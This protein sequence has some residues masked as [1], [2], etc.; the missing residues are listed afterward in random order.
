MARVFIN[1]GSAVPRYALQEDPKAAFTITRQTFRDIENF[2]ADNKASQMR[3]RF[4]M[5]ALINLCVLTVKA[6]AQKQSMGPVAPN[7]RSNPAFAYRVPV[8]RITGRY[9]AGWRVRK[10]GNA[11]WMLYNESKEA[12]LIEYGLYMR[13]RRP[14]LA[15]SVIEMLRLLQ[16][17]QT[18]E[19][20][21]DWILA[22]R[23]D[24]AGKFVSFESRLG[25]MI[26][27]RGSA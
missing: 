14:V 15:N 3:A 23:R 2:I 7:R 4:G 8:Q 17:T 11:T 9:F 21:M 10:L 22:P 13:Q 18:G 26:A 27:D 1:P 19:R 20:F 24:A 12:Y 6:A 5:D 25:S 16:T